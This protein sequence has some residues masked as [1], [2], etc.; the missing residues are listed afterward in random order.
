MNADKLV[1]EY[2]ADIKVE[3]AVTREQKMKAYKAYLEDAGYVVVR[4]QEWDNCDTTII[5]LNMALKTAM[6]QVKYFRE[7]NIELSSRLS[8]KDALK[9]SLTYDNYTSNIQMKKI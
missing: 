7:A 5:N 2:I 8:V 4:K 3:K 9:A 1:D 6:D